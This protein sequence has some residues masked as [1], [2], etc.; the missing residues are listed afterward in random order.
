M[1]VV[2]SL[3]RR[4]L[5]ACN[6]PDGLVG[7]IPFAAAR[8]RNLARR[9]AFDAIFAS[10]PP[11]SVVLAGAIA[12]RLTGR[13]WVADLRDAWVEDPDDPFGVIGGSF[14]AP[15]GRGRIRVL[16]WMEALCLRS[17]RSI[18][19]T[20][21]H[22]LERY[23]TRYPDLG[24]RAELVLNGVDERDFLVPPVAFANF[25][26]AHTGTLHD[27]QR[28]NVDLLLRAFGHAR[29]RSPGVATLYLAGHIGDSLRAWLD[30]RIAGLGLA[31]S[32]VVDGTIPYARAIAVMKG[33]GAILLLAGRNRFMRLTKVSD[34]AA[35]GR[36]ILA[37]AAEDGETGRCV[38]ELGGTV[39]SGD[40]MEELAQILTR[41]Q[42]QG[43]PRPDEHHAFPFPYPHPANWRTA[44][45]QVARRLDAITRIDPQR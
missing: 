43:P 23:A 5:L 22:T 13:P 34:A 16:R 31:D 38:R 11:F 18:L 24:P 40:S 36:P 33:A 27:Y 28:D 32:V 45:E 44:A 19:F 14:R 6:T 17:A 25:T 21:R 7:W 4:V 35:A 1:G 12:S 30:G 3:A 15:Y 10:G 37:L 39:Y 26:F 9:G 42:E 20:S 29:V 8:A 2:E 41:L